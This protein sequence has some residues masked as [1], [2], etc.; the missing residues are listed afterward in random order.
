METMKNKKFIEELLWCWSIVWWKLLHKHIDDL[1]VFADLMQNNIPLFPSFMNMWKEELY[2]FLFL[3]CNIPVHAFQTVVLLKKNIVS[4]AQRYG[5]WLNGIYSERLKNPGFFHG[6]SQW[7]VCN[8]INGN[9]SSIWS[10]SFSIKPHNNR[11]VDLAF[12]PD[13]FGIFA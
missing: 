13:T 9:C 5:C 7:M 6:G 4:L 11:F 3:T 2:E 10:F 1:M 12:R 8:V